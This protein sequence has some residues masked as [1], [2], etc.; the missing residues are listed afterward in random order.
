M[1]IV[2]EVD[3]FVEAYG[4]LGADIDDTLVIGSIVFIISFLGILSSLSLIVGVLRRS[5]CFLFPWLVWHVVIILSL[6]GIGYNLVI[7]FTLLVVKWRF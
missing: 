6:F 7:N 1:G 2:I 3:S 5:S 4:D